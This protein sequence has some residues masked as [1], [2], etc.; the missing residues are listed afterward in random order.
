MAKWIY[1]DTIKMQAHFYQTSDGDETTRDDLLLEMRLGYPI[2]M[3]YLGP[4]SVKL[5]FAVQAFSYDGEAMGAVVQWCRANDRLDEI[6]EDVECEECV[7]QVPREGGGWQRDAVQMYRTEHVA[8][9]GEI[10]GYEDHQWVVPREAAGK[11]LWMCPKCDSVVTEPVDFKQ[12]E[13]FSEQVPKSVLETVW[14]LE[15]PFQAKRVG[16]WS[17]TVQRLDNEEPIK[18]VHI[19]ELEDILSEGQMK[20]LRSVYEV[21][22]DNQKIK[23]LID[24][25]SL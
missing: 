9:E 13:W 17:A 24:E 18:W 25:L 7:I 19:D 4:G 12:P 11:H 14:V 23:E 15:R 5:A 6:N 8:A 21:V 16:I 2:Y 10:I 22:T 3:I 1:D 20:D